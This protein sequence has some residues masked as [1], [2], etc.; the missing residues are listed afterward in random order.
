MTGVQ[1]CALPICGESKLTAIFTSLGAATQEAYEAAKRGEE[2]E[3]GVDISSRVVLLSP[4][5][6]S[7]GM[8]ENEFDRGDKFKKVVRLFQFVD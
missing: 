1:T 4:G 2:L 6:A 3:K 5:C 7:F 8:F